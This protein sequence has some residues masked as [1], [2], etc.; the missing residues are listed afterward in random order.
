MLAGLNRSNGLVGFGRWFAVLSN[1]LTTALLAAGIVYVVRLVRERRENAATVSLPELGDG[2]TFPIGTE[3][4]Y[5]PTDSDPRDLDF[6]WLETSTAAASGLDTRL[7]TAVLPDDGQAWPELPDDDQAWPV[8]SD[9]GHA[10]GAQES[11]SASAHAAQM[12]A[13]AAAHEAKMQATASAHE[14]KMQAKAAAHEAK[15]QATAARHQAKAALSQAKQRAKTAAF[16]E[17]GV[18]VPAPAHHGAV[19]WQYAKA[20]ERSKKPVVRGPGSVLTGAVLGSLLLMAAAA[21]AISHFNLA[22]PAPLGS[23]L[24]WVGAGVAVIGAAIILVGFRGRRG[25]FLNLLAILGLL[26]IPVGATLAHNAEPSELSARFAGTTATVGE[27]ALRGAPN[28]VGDGEFVVADRAQAELGFRS[29]FGDPIIDLT[30]VELPAPGG[31]PVTVPISLRAG[32][33][34]VVV[35]EDVAVAANV[36]LMAGDIS[37]EVD[38]EDQSVSRFGLAS[39][40]FESEEVGSGQPQ[41]V[42]LIDMGVGNIT[43]R[44]GH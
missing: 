11:T 27:F 2:A 8:L 31:A 33:L 35:P 23:P 43:V 20:L 4:G 38:D 16:E 26:S 41:L 15:M 10:S 3:A 22:V 30:H 12:Q 18:A 28:P 14:A 39:A 7:A 42:L 24:A 5:V 21:Q 32:D 19:A 1:I 29:R 40:D 44:E 9:D 34:T 37:W 17:P 36:R 6:D 13:S 25:G